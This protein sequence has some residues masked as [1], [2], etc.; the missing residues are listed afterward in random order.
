MLQLTKLF[1]HLLLRRGKGQPRAR[2]SVRTLLGKIPLMGQDRVVRSRPSELRRPRDFQPSCAGWNLNWIPSWGKC[3]LSKTGIKASCWAPAEIAF[4]H[5]PGH[6]HRR[7]SS[8]AASLLF[9][10][11]PWKNVS[12]R[13]H[14]ENRWSAPAQDQFLVGY[15]PVSFSMCFLHEGSFNRAPEETSVCNQAIGWQG[16]LWYQ[17]NLI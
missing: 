5:L 1:S 6:L 16:T 8:F 9:G 3:Q 2:Q 12:L 17:T 15:Q 4:L 14:Q 7:P 10:A 13:W 11:S